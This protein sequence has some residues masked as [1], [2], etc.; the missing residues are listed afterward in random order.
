MSERFDPDNARP[1]DVLA[2]IHRYLTALKHCEDK[3]VADIGCGKGLGTYLISL[4]AKEIIAVDHNQEALNY[5]D[6]FPTKSPIKKIRLDLEKT[7]PPK[8]DVY[9]VL[10]VIEHLSNPQFFLKHADCEKIC[11]SVPLNSLMIS[12]Y[13]KYDIKSQQDVE[14]LIKPYFQ[15]QQLELLYDIWICGYGIK[16]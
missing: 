4:V 12:T 13:H 7:V 3:V 10:E 2:D 6:K 5:L 9:V 11:F 14:N 1:F 15:I 8:A 16:I